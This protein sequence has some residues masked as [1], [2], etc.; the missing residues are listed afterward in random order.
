MLYIINDQHLTLNLHKKQ[1]S[2]HLI[3]IFFL[4]G[5]AS[6]SSLNKII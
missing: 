5:I 3:S 1:S 6:L 2:N 4:S